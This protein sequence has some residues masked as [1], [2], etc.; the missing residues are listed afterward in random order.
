MDNFRPSRALLPYSCDR[1]A[2]NR[3][4][5][6][7]TESRF[8]II[9]AWARFGRRPMLDSANCLIHT[10]TLAVCAS[11]CGTSVAD[12]I[13]NGSFE[14]YSVPL[15]NWSVPSVVDLN[16][17][18]GSTN[19]AGWAII[20]DT[21]DYVG[22]GWQAADGS[23]SLD[24]AGNPG[25][26]GVVQVFATTA[27]TMYNVHFSMSG[28]PDPDFPSES[29]IKSLRVKA[30]ASS[31]D[32]T[33]DTQAMGNTASDMKWQSHDFVFMATQFSTTLGFFRVGP[34]QF[35]GAALDN[36]SIT[37]VPEPPALVIS[38]IAC[39]AISALRRR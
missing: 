1:D 9:S 25:A 10:L 31:Q 5:A 6:D 4:E 30:A 37:V 20:N 39:W 7:D 8:V 36:V 28:N 19:I 18:Q 32:F 2:V 21:I 26:G 34:S 15:A 35:T 24:L 38:L 33:F 29:S 13:A 16:V 3:V 27:G 11:M 17:P 22:S 23:R 14:S 12:F